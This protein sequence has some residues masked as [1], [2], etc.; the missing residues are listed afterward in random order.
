MLVDT[1]V[2]IEHLR[3]GSPALSTLLEGGGVRTHPLVIGELAC[4]SLGRRDT[5]LSLLADLP[6]CPEVSHE[7][8]MH[9][10]AAHELHSR[11][12][13]WIDIHLLAS[14]RLSGVGLWTLDGRLASAARGL[15]LMN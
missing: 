8:A 7:E 10:L 15:G 3:R 13:G 4:G 14:A 1:S 12:L 2:W 6:G 5:I 11:G 9:F